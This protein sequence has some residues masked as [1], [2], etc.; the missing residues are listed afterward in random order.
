MNEPS[1]PFELPQ[2]PNEPLGPSTPFVLKEHMTAREFAEFAQRLNPELARENPEESYV[3]A[4]AYFEGATEFMERQAYNLRQFALGVAKTKEQIRTSDDYFRLNDPAEVNRLL[5][6]LS[7]QGEKLKTLEG[8]W[9]AYNKEGL[10]SP[11]ITETTSLRLSKTGQATSNSERPTE[12]RIISK[13]F[14]DKLIEIRRHHRRDS[15]A[16][17]KREQRNKDS[18]QETES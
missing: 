13:I 14:V 15:D 9:E 4:L 11:V 17:R 6:Y 2:Q 3:R 12:E 1:S 16:K 7:E 5:S 8:F 10:P 18:T